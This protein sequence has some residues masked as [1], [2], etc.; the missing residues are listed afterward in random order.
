[1]NQLETNRQKILL[2]APRLDVSFKHNPTITKIPTQIGQTLPGKEEWGIFANLLENEYKSRTDTNFE[3]LNLALW[4][5]NYEILKNYE[6]DTIFVPHKEK[7]NFNIKNKHV[8]YYMQTTFPWIFSVD[9]KGWAGG[10]SVYPY[11]SL[12]KNSTGTTTVF[13][14]LRLRALENKSKFQQPKYTDIQLPD[15][16]AL[17]TCQIPD[18]ETV[19]YHSSVTVGKALIYTC[20]ATR[21]LGIPLVVKGHPINE[22]SMIGL[23]NSLRNYSHV[24]YLDKVS[25]HQ[26]I[27]RSKCVVTVNSGTGMEALLHKKPVVTFGQAEYDCVT[28]HA[29]KNT[30]ADVLQNLTYNLDDVIRFF[31]GWYK[32]CYDIT[33]EE[34]F[35]K[36]P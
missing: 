18:D 23:K 3:R 31:D 10:A 15:E 34:S 28:N 14:T 4:Q 36:L 35:K 25:I 6:Y 33:I 22:N 24:T 21:K 1:V 29:T 19:K 20:E 27:G 12:Y 26:L 7:H 2:L 9:S 30:I 32:W 5:F 16:F 11:H 17:F 13:D 8:Y